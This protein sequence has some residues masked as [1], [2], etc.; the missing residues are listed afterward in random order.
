[1]GEIKDYK[2][3]YDNAVGI[4][5]EI[6]KELSLK[7]PDTYLHADTMVMLAKVIK[8]HEKAG[9][10]ELP[11]DHALEAE[12]LGG[13]VNYG[14]EKAGPRA[15]EY[16]TKDPEKL[17]ELKP[18]DFESGR[19]SEVIKACLQLKNEGEKLVVEVQGPF[20]IMNVL[21]DPKYIF[22]T[23]RKN[24]ELAKQI[25]WK[26]GGEL[27]KYIDKLAENGVDIISYADSAGGVNILGPKLSEEVV[28]DFTYEFIKK[29]IEVVNKR[30]IMVLCPKTM[31]AL[32]GTQKAELVDRAV[33]GEIRY[34]DGC[35]E[36]IGKVALAGQTC[37]KNVNYML[38]GSVKEVVLK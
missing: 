35:L 19:I 32:I 24:R 10:C 17:L 3:T 12:A 5:P 20:T 27:L 23:M 11:F 29:A 1:M 21:L 25:Y 30:S 2:C 31:L 15:K 6:T 7:F 34:G 14:D 9:W 28:E 8:E 16:I 33:S 4:S 18:I 22:K 37:I 36:S 13:I 26:F 38:N